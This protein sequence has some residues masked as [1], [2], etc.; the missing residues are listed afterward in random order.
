MAQAT[1]TLSAASTVGAT[2]IKVPSVDGFDAGETI[3]VDAGANLENAVIA[4][5]GTA[6]ATTAR[7]ATDAG[8]TE[9][10]VAG[11]VGFSEGQTIA[12]DSVAKAET[13]VIAA[14][15][16][17]SAPTIIVK[18]PLAQ[19]HE[20]GAQLSGS[21]ITLTKPLTKAHVLGAQLSDNIPTPGVPNRYHRRTH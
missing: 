12:I 13:A 1:A 11:V 8:A 6:G 15:R 17:W 18:S 9:I 3:T 10:P 2:N 19:A 16:P 5:V 20:A 7:A 21:G 4:T 14:I